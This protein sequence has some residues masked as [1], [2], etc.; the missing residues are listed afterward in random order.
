MTG[1]QVINGIQKKEIDYCGIYS[2]ILVNATNER[3]KQLSE[4]G[5]CNKEI[6]KK[7]ALFGAKFVNQLKNIDSYDGMLAKFQI[8][9]GVKDAMSELTPRE[10]ITVFPPSKEYKGKKYGMKDYF[11]TMK[12][13]SDFGIDRKLGDDV[14]EFLFDYQNWDDITDFVVECMITMNR[15]KRYETG[16]DIIEEIFPD[17]KTYT[18]HEM[19]NGK[20]V[21]TDNQTGETTEV[22]KPRPRYL[23]PVN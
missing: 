15:I 8:I 20:K 12:A 4:T 9:C 14:S 18:M 21:M 7:I 5:S 3:T 2:R 13:I 23:K 1:L 10:M 17:I 6:L 16:T 11:S 19:P 22:K